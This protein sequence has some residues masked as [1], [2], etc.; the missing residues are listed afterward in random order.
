MTGKNISDSSKVSSIIASQ[1]IHINVNY[2]D[3]TLVIALFCTL[4]FVIK[5]F[6]FRSCLLFRVKFKLKNIYMVYF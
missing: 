2:L 5:L 6:L 3:T 1:F 4:P